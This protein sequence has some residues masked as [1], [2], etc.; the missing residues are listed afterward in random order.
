[1]LGSLSW[2][3]KIFQ[4]HQSADFVLKMLGL[5]PGQLYLGRGCLHIAGFVF[6]IIFWFTCLCQCWISFLAHLHIHPTDLCIQLGILHL[7]RQNHTE[8][9]VGRN[10]KL[11]NHPVVISR[12]KP[13]H[14]QK[15]PLNDI[16]DNFKIISNTFLEPK[17]YNAG[18]VRTT[19]AF[20]QC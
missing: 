3:K 11:T 19:W 14:T 2:K 8:C 16:E 4:H 20:W 5:I 6:A 1:M 15:F 18:N 7:L 9:T 17:I 10:S 12:I 13:S